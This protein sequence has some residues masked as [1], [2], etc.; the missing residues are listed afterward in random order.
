MSKDPT[1]RADQLRQ[2]REARYGHLQAKAEPPTDQGVH[3]WVNGTKRP[4]KA[5]PEKPVP[6]LKPSERKLVPYAGKETRGIMP[7]VKTGKNPG[8]KR[9]KSKENRT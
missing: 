5:A 9:I 3:P 8:R 1:P 6:A 2:Q 7:A 4:P